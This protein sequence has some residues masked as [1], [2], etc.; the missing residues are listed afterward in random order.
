[1]TGY[2]TTCLMP[3]KRWSIFTGTKF[4]VLYYFY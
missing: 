1:M 4:T 3:I 2:N